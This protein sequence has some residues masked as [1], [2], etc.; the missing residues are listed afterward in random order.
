MSA[1]PASTRPSTPAPTPRPEPVTDPTQ[2]LLILA[3]NASR[4]VDESDPVDYWYRLG[5]RNAY[6]QATALLVSRELTDDVFTITERIT[7]ALDADV[8][9]VDDLRAAAYGLRPAPTTAPRPQLEWTGPKAFDA[10]HHS[11]RG[12]DRDYGMRWGPRSNQRISLRLDGDDATHGL[13]YAYD[14]IWQEYAVLSTHA[15]RAAVDRAYA[16]A[17][18]TDPHLP[19]EDFAVLVSSHSAALAAAGTEPAAPAS[20]V[21]VIEVQL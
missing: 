4:N 11:I 3:R 17:L 13:L 1:T 6:A 21:P 5:Q 2:E 20:P 8:T 7:T 16:Q 18:D 10:Q 12:V 9:D 19:I 15:D 14:P